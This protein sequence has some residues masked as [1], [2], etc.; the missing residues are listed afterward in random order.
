MD[1]YLW[2]FEY[3]SQ[4]DMPRGAVKASLVIQETY[5]NKTSFSRHPEEGYS[6]NSI[7]LRFDGTI[8]SDLAT[9]LGPFSPALSRFK[10]LAQSDRDKIRTSLSNEARDLLDKG[11]ASYVEEE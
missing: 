2:E 6:H 4:D 11:L 5:P 9:S 7:F 1:L 3:P 10:E 8:C